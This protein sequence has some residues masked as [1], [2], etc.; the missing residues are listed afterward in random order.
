MTTPERAASLWPA[1][2]AIGA[3]VLC[4]A[5]P[6]LLAVV[7]T[8]GVLAAV[9]HSALPLAVGLGAAVAL[10][11]AWRQRRACACSDVPALFRG[12]AVRSSGEGDTNP[13]SHPTHV[14]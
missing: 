1:L 11:L 13:R 7:A 8:T 9:A 10:V 6:A 5:G 3:A 14:A 4:C 12:R 2:T